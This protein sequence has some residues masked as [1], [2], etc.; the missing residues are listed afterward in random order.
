MGGPGSAAHYASRFGHGSHVAGIAAGNNHS[1]RFGVARG[2][3]IIAVNVFSYF[4]GQNDVLS[5]YSDQVAGLNYVYSLRNQYNIASANLSLGDSSAYA[6]FCYNNTRAGVFSLL[7]EAG[8]APVVSSGNEGRCN[9]VS[10]PGC[11]PGAVTVASSSK[12]DI[13]SSFGNWHDV[14]MDLV[15]PGEQIVSAYSTGTGAYA[16]ISGTSMSAPH[17]AGAWAVLKQYEPNL[18]VDEALDALKFS[19]TMLTNSSCSNMQPKPRLNVD[20]ALSNLFPVAPPA[21]LSA[22]QET[23]QSFLQNEY[24]NVITWEPNP[25][26]QNKDVV[27]YRLYTSTDGQL[28]QLTDVGASTFTYWHRKQNKREAIV[29]AITA[30][31]ADGFE[32]APTYFTLD[33]GTVQ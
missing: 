20:V 1:D 12:G 10:D 24:L 8:I 2:A 25:A 27:T 13:V 11:V 22:E 26:N 5:Y 29:Y 15:A 6:D 21:N 19:G 14:M 18:S 16:S 23:N 30:I 9:A 31:N 33:F 28:T 7:R 4:S 3:H 17:V 32:S